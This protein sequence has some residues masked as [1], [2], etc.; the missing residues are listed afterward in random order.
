M[1]RACERGEIT[2][3][4]SVRRRDPA[5]PSIPAPLWASPSAPARR[6]TRSPPVRRAFTDRYAAHVPH[7]FVPPVSAASVVIVRNGVDGLEV[8]VVVRARHLAFMGG[9]TAFPGGRVDAADRDSAFGRH[10]GDASF[11]ADELALRVAAIRE[12][13]EETGMV[14]ARASGTGE[15][16]REA[17]L[18]PLRARWRAALLAGGATLLDLVQAEGLELAC[19]ALTPLAHWITPVD[20]PRRFDTRFF[21]T[22]SGDQVAAAVGDENEASAWLAPKRVLDE[23]DAGT[24][25]LPFVTRMLLMRVARSPNVNSAIAAAR[26]ERL[27]P[28]LPRW[29]GDGETR[30]LTIRSDAGYDLPAPASE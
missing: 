22:Q 25:T 26:A 19:D 14:L 8:L 13:L 4:A 27:V 29:E 2:V 16:L 12:T 10:I 6:D 9:A 3:K 23:A 15:L 21:I 18:P 24:R 20:S 30:R 1:R 7:A 17:A 11:A 28:V 5:A